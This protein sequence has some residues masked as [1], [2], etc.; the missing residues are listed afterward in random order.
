M[1][2][3]YGKAVEDELFSVH[4]GAFATCIENTVI[5]GGVLKR[6]PKTISFTERGNWFVLGIWKEMLH[7]ISFLH[8]GRCLFPLPK[9]PPDPTKVNPLPVSFCITGSLCFTQTRAL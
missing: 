7:T 4:F 1:Y 6:Q 2:K 8:G 3:F 5:R 9:H